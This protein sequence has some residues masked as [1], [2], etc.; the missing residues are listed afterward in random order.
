MAL[1]ITPPKRATSLDS[2][3][4]APPIRA[5]FAP[6]SHDPFLA[7]LVLKHDLAFFSRDKHFAHL[8]RIPR[9]QDGLVGG[10][11]DETQDGEAARDLRIHHMPPPHM[12]APTTNKA[13]RT[14]GIMSR[15]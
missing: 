11:S 9:V 10:S 7:A 15:R 6:P 14:M 4:P 5:T 8:A 13:L 12:T 3:S 2:P 1:L